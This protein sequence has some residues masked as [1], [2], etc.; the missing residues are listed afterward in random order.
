VSVLDSLKQAEAAL[1]AVEKEMT[2]RQKFETGWRITDAL[3]DVRESIFTVNHP[4][5]EDFYKGSDL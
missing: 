2:A 5:P 4:M 3:R 1:M